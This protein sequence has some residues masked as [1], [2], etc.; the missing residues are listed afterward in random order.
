LN[1]VYRKNRHR[2][3][4]HAWGRRALLMALLGLG[5]ASPSVALAN[6][7]VKAT[8]VLDPS[9][10][11]YGPPIDDANPEA[12]VPDVKAMNADPLAAAYMV[13]ELSVRAEQAESD[14]DFAAAVRYFRALAKAVPERA[15][16]F[17]KLCQHYQAL[18]ER[19]N[20]IAS[21]RRAT[22]LPGAKL[23]DHLSYAGLLLGQSPP[24]QSLAPSVVSELDATFRHLEG[25]KIDA[26]EVDV[27][28]CKLGLKLEDAARLRSCVERLLKRD[29]DGALTLSHQFS[30]ALLERD[31]SLAE[32]VLER[33]RAAS[34]PTEAVA[35]MQQELELRRGPASTARITQLVG[36]AFTLALVVWALSALWRRRLTVTA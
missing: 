3:P 27:L 17:S 5:S 12:S 22:E 23:A 6:D 34:L 24:G 14:K 11:A 10:G 7:G 33:A 36:G 16:A 15:L 31:F 21:C 30:L 9:E 19:D 26:P 13:M 18:G 32:S 20:A 2:D 29:P 28:V 25:Q 35:L 8:G 1:L 4:L